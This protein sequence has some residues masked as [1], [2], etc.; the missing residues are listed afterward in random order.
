[1]VC[2]GFGDVLG[3]FQGGIGRGRKGQKW[4]DFGVWGDRW[5]GKLGGQIKKS[6]GT[7]VGK[8]RG[9]KLMVANIPFCGFIWGKRTL[10]KHG[11]LA[12]IPYY[13]IYR[14]ILGVFMGLLG[15][16]IV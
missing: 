10:L 16:E 8:M 14:G 7:K 11:F 6:G 1:M 3:M 4:G 9:E 5:G 15:R 12:V 13:I 2:G